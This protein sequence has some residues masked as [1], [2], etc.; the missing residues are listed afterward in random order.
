MLSWRTVQI[1]IFPTLSMLV[2][3]W[4]FFF[5]GVTGGKTIHG[6]VCKTKDSSGVGNGM[7]PC[8]EN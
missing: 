6:T 5:C 1:G 3:H 4:E 7:K 8:A 2:E